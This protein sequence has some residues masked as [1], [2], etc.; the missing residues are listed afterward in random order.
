MPLSAFGGILLGV[1]LTGAVYYSGIFF[2]NVGKRAPNSYAPSQGAAWFYLMVLIVIIALVVALF[3]PAVNKRIGLNVRALLF[4]ALFVM[5]GGM[6][7]CNF[8]GIG[9]LF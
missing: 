9:S 2:A 7:L 4:G 3:F 5:L 8:F 6:A 1:G